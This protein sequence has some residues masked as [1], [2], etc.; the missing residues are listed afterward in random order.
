MTQGNFAN[1]LCNYAC[2]NR[3]PDQELYKILLHIVDADQLSHFEKAFISQVLAVLRSETL[4]LTTSGRD[5]QD[6]S[7]A[8]RLRLAM[9]WGDSSEVELS[10]IMAITSL[11]FVHD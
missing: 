7:M 10:A 4:G 6:L 2:A 9:F 3:R 1:Q 8:E 5:G 11:V